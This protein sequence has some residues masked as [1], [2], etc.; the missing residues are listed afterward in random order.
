MKDSQVS[1]GPE[2]RVAFSFSLRSTSQSLFPWTA[3][4]Q[5]EDGE[6]LWPLLKAGALFLIPTDMRMLIIDQW[7][8]CTGD[9]WKTGD[10]RAE[11]AGQPLCHKGNRKMATHPSTVDTTTVHLLKSRTCQENMSGTLR[12]KLKLWTLKSLPALILNRNSWR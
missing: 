5:T 11:T 3:S 4:V 12:L 1:P 10:R 9:C 7:E 6:G 2:L 8:A